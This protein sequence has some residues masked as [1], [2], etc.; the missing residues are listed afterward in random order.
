MKGLASMLVMAGIWF[1]AVVFLGFVA[2]AFFE[3]ASFGWNLW[4]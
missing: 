2:R 1:F 4:P 3:I